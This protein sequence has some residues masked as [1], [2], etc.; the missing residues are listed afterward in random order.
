V[1]DL[2]PDLQELFVLPQLALPEG[3]WAH[4]D[5]PGSPWLTE[6]YPEQWE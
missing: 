4:R 2:C 1:F 5:A 3:Y 6:P